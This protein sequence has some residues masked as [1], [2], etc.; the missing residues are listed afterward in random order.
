MVA[1]DNDVVAMT[2][3]L[4]S[5]D[6]DCDGDIKGNEEN[7]CATAAIPEAKTRKNHTDGIVDVFLDV[8]FPVF[9]CMACIV[10]NSIHRFNIIERIIII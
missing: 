8:R 6:D 1:A 5:F 10:E 2:A 7:P 9:L 3:D 4:P